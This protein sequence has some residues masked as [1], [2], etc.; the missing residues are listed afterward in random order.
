[1]KNSFFNFFRIA[2]IFFA[3]LNCKPRHNNETDS[4]A[5][6]IFGLGGFAKDV[7]GKR[8]CPTRLGFL[9]SGDKPTWV[10]HWTNSEEAVRN[11]KRYLEELVRAGK[12]ANA[13][14]KKI[15]NGAV[16]NGLYVALDPFQSISYGKI[17]VAF[18]ILPHSIFPLRAEF[19]P[20][21]LFGD[22]CPGT[23]YPFVAGISSYFKG[24]APA[25]V[26]WDLASVSATEVVSWQ[27]ASGA[28]PKFFDSITANELKYWKNSSDDVI[29]F[30]K[31]RFFPFLNNSVGSEEIKLQRTLM[32]D[33][34]NRARE[35]AMKK[36]PVI[37]FDT[38][39]YLVPFSPKEVLDAK[40][41]YKSDTLELWKAC[42]KEIGIGSG[43]ETTFE[44]I[45]NAFDV[46]INKDISAHLQEFKNKN[47]GELERFK[48]VV[49]YWTNAH[50]IESWKPVKE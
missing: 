11:P 32:R 36:R 37:Y 13:D 47:A 30:V 8:S 10:F 28:A 45:V 9:D 3:A 27:P 29:D 7:T 25:L 31:S 44:D 22:G 46:Y 34:Y 14:L 39:F 5:K 2:F 17:L 49:Q 1:M 50:T 38:S 26:L 40:I 35:C 48:Q 41:L 12:S 4:G 42:G 33:A 6:G 24:F 21:S 16:G 18:P 19:T 15:M 20:G 23:V 43:N